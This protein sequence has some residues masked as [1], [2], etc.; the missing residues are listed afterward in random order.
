MIFYDL[1]V[2]FNCSQIDKFT[3]SI[4]S[5]KV[6]LLT[7]AW[8]LNAEHRLHDFVWFIEI[9]AVYASNTSFSGE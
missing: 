8:L 2:S 3:D 6:I 5:E 9:D 7:A 1:I 4:V